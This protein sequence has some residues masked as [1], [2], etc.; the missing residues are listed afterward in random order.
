M[1]IESTQSVV[2]VRDLLAPAHAEALGAAHVVVVA[3]S[4]CEDGVRHGYTT[5]EGSRHNIAVALLALDVKISPK[6]ILVTNDGGLFK[7]CRLF[8]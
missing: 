4:V 7:A 3:H 8:R 6:V 5:L 1:G 2:R